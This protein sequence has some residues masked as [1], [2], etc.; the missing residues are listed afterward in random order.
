MY[1]Y[2]LL[3]FELRIFWLESLNSTYKI[4]YIYKLGIGLGLARDRTRMNGLSSGLA[5]DQFSG[6]GIGSG[7]KF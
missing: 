3:S 5:L 6:L 4:L 7:S 2:Y 1:T